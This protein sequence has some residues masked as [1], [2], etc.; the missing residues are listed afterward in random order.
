MTF[1]IGDRIEAE[2]DDGSY[3]IEGKIVA[4]HCV[5]TGEF[6]RIEGVEIDIGSVVTISESYGF[7]RLNGW[8]WSFEKA[9]AVAA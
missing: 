5:E 2:S 7:E 3:T 1:R 6:T 9:D 8:L 4:G